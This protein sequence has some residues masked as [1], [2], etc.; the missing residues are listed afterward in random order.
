MPSAFAQLTAS[1]S[2][3]L[4]KRGIYLG[5][6]STKLHV[7]LYR[8]S[9]GRFGGHIPGWPQARLL[10][11]DHTGARSGVR[12]TSPLMYQ[13]DGEAIAV[14]ASKAGQPTNPAWFHNLV[15]HPDTTIQIGSEVRPVRAR[16]AAEEERQRLWAKFVALYPGSEAYRRN[17]KGR[18]IP[19]VVLD[20]R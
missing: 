20:P 19:V 14:M 7:A 9:G 18:T 4:N 10:L 5:P 11:L 1:S 12:R 16:V 3:F 8:R 13:E 17:A 15:A 2:E 6:R